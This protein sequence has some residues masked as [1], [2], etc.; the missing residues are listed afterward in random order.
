[1]LFFIYIFIILYV[2]SDNFQRSSTGNGFYLT[3]LAGDSCS[4][5]ASPALKKQMR[6]NIGSTQVYMSIPEVVRDAGWCPV[7]DAK[8]ETL[9][10]RPNNM[11]THILMRKDDEHALLKLSITAVLSPKSGRMCGIMKE[12][13]TKCVYQPEGYLNL[14]ISNNI[15]GQTIIEFNDICIN[16]K[17]MFK[18]NNKCIYNDYIAYVYQLYN[19]NIYE[20]NVGMVTLTQ[21]IKVYRNSNQKIVETTARRD[22]IL[23]AILQ[24]NDE[25]SENTLRAKYNRCVRIIIHEL[26]SALIYLAN[27]GKITRNVTPDNIYLTVEAG[28]LVVRLDPGFYVTDVTGPVDIE[29][30]ELN[31]VQFGEAQKSFACI[32]RET[33]AYQGPEC[34]YSSPALTLVFLEFEGADKRTYVLPYAGDE[35]HSMDVFMLGAVWLKLLK[36]PYLKGD[37]DVLMNKTIQELITHDKK[38]IGSVDK[39]TSMING[40]MFDENKKKCYLKNKS[41]NHDLEKNENNAVDLN[42]FLCEE[43]VF[44]LERTLAMQPNDRI[45]PSKVKSGLEDLFFEDLQFYMKPA[46]DTTLCPHSEL[47]GVSP[48]SPNYYWSVS[49]ADNTLNMGFAE[50]EVE[51]DEDDL[52]AKKFPEAMPGPIM[53]GNNVEEAIPPVMKSRNDEASTARALEDPAIE[54]ETG[55][56]EVQ[57]KEPIVDRRDLEAAILYMKGYSDEYVDVPNSVKARG[58]DDILEIVRL[59]KERG[60]CP[61]G[62]SSFVDKIK[63]SLVATGSETFDGPSAILAAF[64]KINNVFQFQFRRIYAL[65]VNLARMSKIGGG[66][67][68]KVERPVE[69]EEIKPANSDGGNK[70]QSNISPKRAKSFIQIKNKSLAPPKRGPEA[71]RAAPPTRGSRARPAAKSQPIQERGRTK[72]RE[73][74]P[75]P[76]RSSSAPGRIEETGK[77]YQNPA[78]HAYKELKDADQLSYEKMMN[79]MSLPSSSSEEEKEEENEEEDEET[80]FKRGFELAQAKVADKMALI[81]YESLSAF[82]KDIAGDE[83]N[84]KNKEN[85]REKMQAILQTPVKGKTRKYDDSDWKL[86]TAKNV[87]Y[88]N[89]WALSRVRLLGEDGHLGGNWKDMIEQGFDDKFSDSRPEVEA[90]LLDFASFHEQVRLAAIDKDPEIGEELKMRF[91]CDPRLYDQI[92]KR[93]IEACLGFITYA[94]NLLST[95]YE[96][97]ADSVRII[98]K[99]TNRQTLSDVA[100]ERDGEGKAIRKGGDHFNDIIKNIISK[101]EEEEESKNY[102]LVYNTIYTKRSTSPVICFADACDEPGATPEEPDFSCPVKNLPIPD[103]EKNTWPYMNGHFPDNEMCKSRQKDMWMANYNVAHKLEVTSFC[104]NPGTPQL[105]QK[106]HYTNT[107]YIQFGPF[108]AV[109]GPNELNPDEKE[110]NENLLLTKN[111]PNQNLYCGFSRQSR[112]GQIAANTLFPDCENGSENDWSPGLKSTFSQ[113]ES[114]QSAVMFGLGYSG[115]GKSYTLLGNGQRGAKFVPGVLQMALANWKKTYTSE[116]YLGNQSYKE[117]DEGTKF[118]AWINVGELYFT[119]TQSTKFDLETGVGRGKYIRYLLADSEGTTESKYTA[120]AQEMTEDHETYFN[121][122]STNWLFC[123]DSLAIDCDDDVEH[124]QK[125]SKCES[126]LKITDYKQTKEKPRC[127]QS[128]NPETVEEVTSTD[129][130]NWR[131]EK[132]NLEDVIEKGKFQKPLI[133]DSGDHRD[134]LTEVVNAVVHKRRIDGR[135]RGTPNNPDSSRG[136]LFL[137]L[138]VRFP[139]PL[140]VKLEPTYGH[141]VISDLAGAEDPTQIAD[142]Y[143]K[144]TQP[145]FIE[146]NKDNFAVDL[147]ALDDDA[148]K[149]RYHNNIKWM[150]ENFQN[151][152]MTLQP[153]AVAEIL[154]L[155]E[156]KRTMGQPIIEWLQLATRSPEGSSTTNVLKSYFDENDLEL[157]WF[158]AKLSAIQVYTAENPRYIRFMADSSLKCFTPQQKCEELGQYYNFYFSNLK[159]KVEPRAKGDCEFDIRND[160]GL[161]PR[162]DSKKILEKLREKGR[163]LSHFVDDTGNKQTVNAHE[164]LEA[165]NKIREKC[166]K[167]PFEIKDVMMSTIAFVSE[168]IFKT[169]VEGV[170]I[171]ETLNQQALYLTLKSNIYNWKYEGQ[172]VLDA[173]QDYP[174]NHSTD[175]H[176]EPDKASSH[177]EVLSL[178][179]NALYKFM[180]FQ[181]IGIGWKNMGQPA[182]WSIPKAS[183]AVNN[184]TVNQSQVFKILYKDIDYMTHNHLYGIGAKGGTEKEHLAKV[185]QRVKVMTMDP[186]QLTQNSGRFDGRALPNN[187]LGDKFKFKID[188]LQSLDY[189]Q[190]DDFSKWSDLMIPN[191]PYGT[192]TLRTFNENDALSNEVKKILGDQIK[193]Q[194]KYAKGNTKGQQL[195]IN[196]KTK[197]KYDKFKFFCAGEDG[198]SCYVVRVL[199]RKIW[200]LRTMEDIAMSSL[201]EPLP[202]DPMNIRLDKRNGDVLGMWNILDHFHTQLNPPSRSDVQPETKFIMVA[203]LRNEQK[204]PFC[205]GTQSTLEFADSLN[206][207]R[208]RNPMT[209]KYDYPDLRWPMQE[210]FT[211]TKKRREVLAKILTKLQQA[212]ICRTQSDQARRDEVLFTQRYSTDPNVMG[213]LTKDMKYSK[214][215]VD[216]E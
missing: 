111:E 121:Y 184:L 99:V 43:E 114:G 188:N 211:G 31:R 118:Q 29:A 46:K 196:L 132:I 105:S 215:K 159:M 127:L 176:S 204:S 210:L 8:M 172:A 208:Q 113:V 61:T 47:S 143:L 155:D 73:G 163:P 18:K 150:I 32:P 69:S 67:V 193:K 34:T 51:I 10:D 57:I 185:E 174:W 100:W 59:C 26:S 167:A 140:G 88:Q 195:D 209:K 30:P 183:V 160:T 142:P 16:I 119:T 171:N 108:F 203:A 78:Y 53:L 198:L 123:Q 36:I 165:V 65:L 74:G 156:V 28:A 141:L 7:V 38:T 23:K 139:A 168:K 71:R 133:E 191:G 137:V 42:N 83:A 39:N 130:D 206:P 124:L 62:V 109:F 80:L 134:P 90:I 214:C 149:E 152:R 177:F 205:R 25:D 158:D 49:D 201:S 192:S 125:L 213:V 200:I 115:S 11:D 97:L 3:E 102:P 170:F 68:K 207:L 98:I 37:Y 2:K 162:K 5:D 27:I 6:V 151:S 112:K 110:A 126:K 21:F 169:I 79:M 189:S 70:S 148:T 17:N 4:G 9:V 161:I 60:K 190:F 85:R 164:L 128:P 13:I 91:D 48:L 84:A 41:I 76:K 181:G 82:Y 187:D 52:D 120:Y 95:L 81:M 24:F 45:H 101:K 131:A 64:S 22:F 66:E 55:G 40:D 147:E 153:N 107:K 50:V 179:Q 54:I 15:C 129:S 56:Q 96:D 122:D 14:Y 186:V 116:K 154:E 89:Y 145:K 87:D 104:P 12:I 138:R 44:L 197:E 157:G 175:N 144:F 72:T 93:K 75:P 146:T 178:N 212:R 20:D 58:I 35:P 106:D 1:M 33:R 136:H 86:F 180:R 103:I 19:I 135:E 94:E 173:M 199:R 63:E 202:Y 117:A 166:Q 216:A 92:K 182:H 194:D 77:K